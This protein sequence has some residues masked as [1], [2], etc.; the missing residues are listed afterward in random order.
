MFRRVAAW[1]NAEPDVQAIVMAPLA[2]SRGEV[3]CAVS[4]LL[5]VPD[6]AGRA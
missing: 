6:E 1:A 5:G 4:L 3:L 2:L